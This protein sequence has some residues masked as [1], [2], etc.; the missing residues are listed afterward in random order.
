MWGTVSSRSIVGLVCAKQSSGLYEYM[1]FG[2][3]LH[4]FCALF[5]TH[6]E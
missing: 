1:P 6:I 4:T 2:H 5:L 3:T